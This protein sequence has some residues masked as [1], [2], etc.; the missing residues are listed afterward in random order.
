MYVM[1]TDTAMITLDFID[2]IMIA[3]IRLS[4]NYNVVYIPFM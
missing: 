3:A 1:Y 2:A 4:L